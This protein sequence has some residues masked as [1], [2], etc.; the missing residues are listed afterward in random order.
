MSP[1]RDARPDAGAEESLRDTL[2]ARMQRLYPLCRS[3]TGDGV[4]RTLDFLAEDLPLER[5]AV[6]SGTHVFDWTVPDEWNLREAWIEGPDGR[7]VVDV[8]D[9][10]LH[11][12]S[13]SEPV[14]ARL[15]R[16][17]LAE[18]VHTLPEHPGWIPYRTS[19]YRRAWAFCMEHD[20]WQ[21]LTDGAYD[22]CVNSTLEPG[23]LVY[24]ECFL[25]GLSEQEILFSTHVCHPSMANDNLS[26]IVL[27]TE[28]FRWLAR[29]PR[30]FSYRAV[31]VPGTIGSLCWLSRNRDGLSRIRAG[32]VITGVGGPGALVYKRSRR[33]NTATDRA[34]R[35][36]L[37]DAGVPHEVRRFD[38]YGYDERQYCSP[39][40]DLP[41]GRLTR[42]PHGEYP[43]YHTSADDLGFVDPARIE[44]ALDCCRRFVEHLEA[45]SWPVSRAPYGEPQLG[46]RGLF[47]SVG[48]SAPKDSVM[49]ML[50]VMSLADGE[51]SLRDLVEASG[52]S[53]SAIEAACARLEDAGL[54]SLDGG[55]VEPIA[56]GAQRREDTIA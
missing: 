32:L 42:T 1:D 26:G 39:G 19:Y 20:R 22:V 41:V 33:G 17:E 54:L 16:A 55:F 18:H 56:G 47:D 21:G 13:Y 51:H 36:V 46:R 48:G 23:E 52:L 14:R 50:W 53:R 5:R 7:R 44:D 9:H 15:S 8:A 11:V 35:Q 2:S 45:E 27:Q 6:P 43:E 31:F 40:I 25:P 30:R 34:M 37:E 38:P 28:L 10:T 4:R 3:I 24:G 49:A 12:M 29:R